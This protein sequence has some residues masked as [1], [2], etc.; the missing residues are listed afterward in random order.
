MNPYLFAIALVALTLIPFARP[1]IRLRIKILRWF[2]WT[3]AVNLL[4]KHFERWVVIVRVIL[5]LVAVALFYA[6]WEDLRV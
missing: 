3:W 6:G 1:L 5:F 4:E 2:R